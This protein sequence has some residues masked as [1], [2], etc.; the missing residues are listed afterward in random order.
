[1]ADVA[2]QQMPAEA[3]AQDPVPEAPKRRKRKT[4]AAGPGPSGAQKACCL[5]EIWQV[6]KIKRKARENH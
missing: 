5:K 3:P 2:G 4:R 1:M 6:H